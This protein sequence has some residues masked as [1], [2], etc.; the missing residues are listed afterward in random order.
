[1]R[2]DG[3]RLEERGDEVV[4]DVVDLDRGEPQALDAGCRTGLPDEPGERVARGPVAEAA[5]VDAG[6]HD[7]AMPLG[8]PASYLAEHRARA[9]APRGSADEGDHA[10]RARE[11]AS[12]LDLHEGP[13]TIEA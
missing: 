8:D 6:E 13:H 1:M 12:V 4:V 7:L 11:R 10:E 5:E 9:T 3:R 2:R